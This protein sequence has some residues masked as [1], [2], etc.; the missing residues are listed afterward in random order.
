MA[1][2]AS[3]FSDDIWNEL[4]RIGA[5]SQGERDDPA[6]DD[7]QSLQGDYALRAIAKL[8]EV[9]QAFT[10][11]RTAMIGLTRDKGISLNDEGLGAVD[12]RAAL[13]L[14]AFDSAPEPAAEPETTTIS[15]S[16]ATFDYQLLARLQQ[17]CKYYLGFGGRSKKH[18][19]ALDEAEQIQKMKELY[20]ALP[21]KPEWITLADIENYELAMVGPADN[22]TEQVT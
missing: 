5:I 2:S 10:E 18:L 13:A 20:A 4:C 7:N 9:R 19:W 3:D 21:E 17:D 15:N 14:G 6:L 8:D 16:Y 1:Y 11:Y 22:R 12:E